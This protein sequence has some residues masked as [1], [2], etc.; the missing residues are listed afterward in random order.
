MRERDVRAL[1]AEHSEAADRRRQVGR[2]DPQRDVGAVEPECRAAALCMRGDRECSTGSPMTQATRV[3]PPIVT[4]DP[5]A[6]SID[7]HRLRRSHRM[8][9]GVWG[10]WIVSGPCRRYD[11]GQTPIVHAEDLRQSTHMAPVH[12]WGLTP[13]VQRGPLR[14]APPV[15]QVTPG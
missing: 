13:I 1:E 3:A 2:R 8:S 5:E 14:R 9:D 12:D 7:G 15:A 6:S 11:W 4:P 10:A